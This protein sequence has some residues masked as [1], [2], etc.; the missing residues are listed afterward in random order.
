MGAVGCTS[1]STRTTC[2]TIAS[3]EGRGARTLPA[4]RRDVLV[5]GGAVGRRAAELRTPRDAVLAAPLRRDRLHRIMRVVVARVAP[6]G[7]HHPAHRPHVARE[8]AVPPGEDLEQPA[9]HLSPAAP[10]AQDQIPRVQRPHRPGVH[11][12][13]ELRKEDVVRPSLKGAGSFR[14]SDTQ[15]DKNEKACISVSFLPAT[16]RSTGPRPSCRPRTG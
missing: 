14:I 4:E 12:C 3:D 1:T 5:A 11:A 6:A 15:T 7:Q 9:D 13:K 8:A 16:S 10:A 2:T